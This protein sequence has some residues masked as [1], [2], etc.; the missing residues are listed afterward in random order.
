MKPKILIVDGHSM[1]FAWSDLARAHA[2]N[3]ASARELLVRM[4]TSLQDAGE[5]QVAVV[6]DGKGIRP[7]SEN[8]PEHAV[9]IFYSRSGQTADSIIERL[10]AK[11]APTCDVT[12]ATNDHMERLTV[13][14]FGA[15]SI[16]ADQLLGEI[17][18]AQ[19]RVQASIASI[20]RRVGQKGIHVAPKPG[21]G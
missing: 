13:E 8:I 15:M 9:G 10:A 16:S 6:F 4:L 12:V 5:W 14:S 21:S 1:I 19:S 2:G 20:N 3:T 11:Y 17:S 18:A 7:S